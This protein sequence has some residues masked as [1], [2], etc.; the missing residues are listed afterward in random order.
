MFSIDTLLVFADLFVPF[1]PYILISLYPM[2]KNEK[3]QTVIIS[4]VCFFIYAAVVFFIMTKNGT[5]DFAGRQ[6]LKLYATLPFNVIPFIIFKNRIWQ[7]IF[8]F[9]INS[10]YYC[11]YNGSGLF[12]GQHEL[13]PFSPLLSSV[14]VS[15]AVIIITLP[16]L[17]ILLRH[18]YKNSAALHSNAFWRLI[19]LV[20]ALYFS[21]F[22]ATG[23]QLDPSFYT[24]FNVLIIRVVLYLTLLITCVLLNIAIDQI[25]EAESAK[26]SEKIAKVENESLERLSILKSNFFNDMSHELRTPL[27]IIST[28]ITYADD[29]VKTDGNIEKARNALRD[30]KNETL[31]IG[32]MLD[33]MREVANMNEV[34][35]NRKR[36]DLAAL[37]RERTEAFRIRYENA[38][39]DLF[40]E[41][42]D[43]IPDVFIQTDKFTGVINNLLSNAL[44]H[45]TDGN[46]TVYAAASASFITVRVT[47][48]GQGIAPEILPVI[49]ERGVSGRGGTGY[50]LAICKSIIEA[51]GGQITA[52]NRKG[53]YGE[54]IGASF[55][56]TVPVYGGQEAG[57][58]L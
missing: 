49:F 24:K 41:I 26:R 51:H 16:P 28:G 53:I 6:M 5:P 14:V 55:K 38:G 42:D 34:A 33:G 22:M 7:N 32:R 17:L 3:K 43:N 47:D 30:A 2:W 19:W 8:L 52:E 12:A 40:L 48:T 25:S 35:E 11:I 9:S 13:F 39:V 57:R 10:L 27:A 46:I 20:P 58:N 56:F 4:I 29:E 50:G 37:I 15:I 36:A 31:R 44:E 54:T 18:L 1:I 21:L 23:N 45:T